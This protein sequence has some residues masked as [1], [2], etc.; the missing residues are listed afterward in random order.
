MMTMILM[1]LTVNRNLSSQLSGLSNKVLD[2]CN[3]V[4]RFNSNELAKSFLPG[5]D[6]VDDEENRGL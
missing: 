1:W 5:E 4:T 2:C 3:K 6:Q